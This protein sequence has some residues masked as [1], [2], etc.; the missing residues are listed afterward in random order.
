MN[1]KADIAYIIS[2]G[3]A[4]RMLL[5]TD[6]L[7]KLLKKGLKVAVITPHKNDQNLLDYAAANNIDLIEYNPNSSLWTSEYMRLRKYLF[8]DI[9][10]NAALWE[11]H[12]RDLN[13]AKNRS[14]FKTVLKIRVYYFIYLLVNSIPF[15]RKLFAGFERWSLKDPVADNILKELNPRLLITTYPVNLTE[16]RLL[17]AGNKAAGTGTVIHLLSWDNIT[18]KGYFSQLADHYISWGNIMKQE[19][20]EYYKIREDKIYNTGVPHF[21]LHKQVEGSLVYKDILRKKGLD[22]GIPYI[23]FALGAPYFSPTEIDI[24]AWLAKKIEEKAF[25]EFQLLIRP[26]PQNLSS[27][28]A[29]TIMVNRLKAME[30]NLVKIDW[31]KMLESDLNWSMQMSDML[32]FAHMLEGCKLSINSGSTVSIDSLLHDKPV[33]QPLFDVGITL[34][35]W[36]SVIRVNDYKHCKKLVDLGGVTVANNFDEFTF[37]LDR[38]L[39]DP[40]YQ[41]EKRQNALYQ[42]VG[43]NDGKATE[44]VVAAIEQIVYL[45]KEG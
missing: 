4:A 3:F 44:R 16:S 1:R 42:E 18:C 36:Q 10:K 15:I 14:S 11:K 2:H 34:P 38:Y 45:T 35:W 20:I 26:H 41:L 19:F 21:D 5:Q 31:P 7:G 25:G 28:T 8:E 9:R 30:T 27:K 33:I 24:A 22:P 12:L 13:T 43:V 23:F 17:Y 32:E 40:S 39:K 29:D 6:L 37:E